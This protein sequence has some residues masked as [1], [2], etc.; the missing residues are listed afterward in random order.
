MPFQTGINMG[1]GP[2]SSFMGAVSAMGNQMQKTDTRLSKYLLFRYFDFTVTPGNS[3]R[4]RVRLVLRNPNYKRPV[5]ELVDASVAEGELR[6]TPWSEP[7]TPSDIPEEQKVFLAKVDKGRPESGVA[8]AANMDIVQWFA[9]AGTS[10]SVK[11]EKLQLGQFVGG[12][13][14]TEVLRPEMSLKEEEI[15]VFTGSILADIAMAPLAELDAAEHADLKVDAKRLKQIGTVDKALLVDRFGQLM[16][17]DPKVSEDDQKRSLRSVE[18]EHGA[19]AHLKSRND[20]AG[21]NRPS[22]LDR[23]AGKNASAS[24]SSANMME[25]MMGSGMMGGAPSPQKKGAAGKAGKKQPRNSGGSS[26]GGSSSGGSSSGGGSS[27]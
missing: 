6:M 7:T 16:A 21:A 9:D 11:L 8:P 22:D 19:W 23:L 17:L 18:D 13:A 26:S 12:R 20:A 4:Y 14:K 27:F 3:Y 15:P 25:M 5:E 10:I 2:S 24:G 1:S